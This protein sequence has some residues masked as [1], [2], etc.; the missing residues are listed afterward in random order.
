MVVWKYDDAGGQV[1]R[2]VEWVV[3]VQNLEALRILIGCSY[4]GAGFLVAMGALARWAVGRVM[5]GIVGLS[6]VEQIL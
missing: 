1:G 3:A 4:L 2:G 6:G 5:L